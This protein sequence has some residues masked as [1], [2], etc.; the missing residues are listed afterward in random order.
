MLVEQ[1]N[2]WY[3]EFEAGE[4]FDF[5]AYREYLKNRE[6]NSFRMS[7]AMERFFEYVRYLEASKAE[8]EVPKHHD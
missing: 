4:K 1:R 2:G 3:A 8:R 7:G 5:P 6:S